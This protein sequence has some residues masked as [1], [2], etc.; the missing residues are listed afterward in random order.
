MSDTYQ[1][2]WKDEIDLFFSINRTQLLESYPG[3]RLSRIYDLIE[4]LN[5]VHDFNSECLRNLKRQ[6]LQQVPL[7]YISQL[8]FFYKNSFYVDERVLIPRSESEILVERIVHIIKKNKGF[9]SIAE[10][11]VGSGALLLS[12]LCDCERSLTAIGTDISMAALEVAKKNAFLKSHLISPETKLS[13]YWADRLKGF[14][15]KFDIIIS[16]PPYI[17]PT[18]KISTHPGVY[19]FEPHQAL[20][21]S[22][23]IYDSWFDVFFGEVVDCLK[24]GGYFMMEGHENH[25]K[26]L[27]EILAG[28]EF[29]EIELIKDY[30]GRDRFILAKRN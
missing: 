28:L 22:D 4:E 8:A 19:K 29:N 3:L 5:P 21:L 10:V 6:L 17:K 23:E 14:T 15:Q 13:F 24:P 11:G 12:I 20:F 26:G 27:R 2:K 16:N 7:Q 25:L 9:D 30:N 18:D 1:Y